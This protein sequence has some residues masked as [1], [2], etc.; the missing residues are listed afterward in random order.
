MNGIESTIDSIRR[1]F[2]YTNKLKDSQEELSER[3]LEL[4]DLISAPTTI[5][6]AG[7]AL[8]IH[9]S[10]RIDTLEGVCEVAVGRGFDLLDGFCARAF[11]QESD[12]GALVDASC[13]KIGMGFMVANAWRKNVVPKEALSLIIASNTINASL[14]GVAALRNPKIRYRPPKNGKHAMS[15]YNAGLIG[16]AYA[17]V[18]EK[19]FPE[20]HLHEPIRTLSKV[21]IIAGTTLAIP[22]AGEYLHRAI[23]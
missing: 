19:E 3:S 20:S 8:V 9:G 22:A 10:K 7:L 2:D 1:G 11:E 15:F 13:D 17:H 5:S 21:A 14:S 4:K 23:D 16:Y 12:M 6:L 18:L